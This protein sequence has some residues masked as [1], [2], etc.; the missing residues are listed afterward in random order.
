MSYF[1][2]RL[3]PVMTEIDRER[4][5]Q[6]AK[7]GE[8]NW[9]D[10]TGAAIPWPLFVGD[11]RAAAIR[12]RDAAN[13]RAKR[14]DLTFRDI[15]TDEVAATYAESDPSKLRAELVQVAAVAC[16]WIEAI[17]RRSR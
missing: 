3:R 16:A 13:R 12:A 15:L 11:G 7:W 1:P 6:D 4:D 2:E 5:A 17:D 10:G 9:P 8:Q 14:G